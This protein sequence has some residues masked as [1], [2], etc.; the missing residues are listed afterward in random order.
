MLD[1]RGYRASL[2]YHSI[3]VMPIKIG[4]VGSMKVFVE[5]SRSFG[6]RLEAMQR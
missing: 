5:V 1:P 6:G 3:S 2:G 4:I